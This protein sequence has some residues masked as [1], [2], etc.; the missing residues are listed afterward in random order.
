M[1]PAPDIALETSACGTLLKI[2]SAAR[3]DNILPR[4]ADIDPGALKAIMPQVAIVAIP[5]PGLNEIRLAGT[6]YR[7]IFGFETTSQNLT[8]ISLPEVRRVRAYRFWTGVTWPC[9][10]W[11]F[12][13]FPY[14]HGTSDRFEFLSLPLDANVPDQPRM[15]LC[16]IGSLLGRQWKNDRPAQAIVG[17]ADTFSFVDIGAG[18]P[19]S[20]DPPADFVAEMNEA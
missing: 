19:P 3:A 11:A 2:W 1:K 18:V 5:A 15:T 12:L 20:L 6:A 13:S 10:G 7:D 16:A 8:D 4:R 14:A 17:A 9:A